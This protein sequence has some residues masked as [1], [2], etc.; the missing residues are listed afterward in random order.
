MHPQR[1]VGKLTEPVKSSIFVRNPNPSPPQAQGWIQ[2][3]SEGG[4]IRLVFFLFVFVL[5]VGVQG[6]NVGLLAE[7]QGNV[8]L[9]GLQQSIFL[10]SSSAASILVQARLGLF[11]GLQLRREQEWLRRVSGGAA[12]GGW[13][14][15][16]DCRLHRTPPSTPTRPRGG[17]RTSLEDSA[18]NNNHLDGKKEI[19]SKLLMTMNADEGASGRPARREAATRVGGGRGG[20]R[21]QRRPRHYNALPSPESGRQ[22]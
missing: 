22:H 20:Q 15:T 16:A 6:S 12:R 11:P 19:V 1:H 7:I 21:G 8:V 9:V 10:P 17:T 2:N 4:Q 3:G 5:G 18:A 13:P 14:Q